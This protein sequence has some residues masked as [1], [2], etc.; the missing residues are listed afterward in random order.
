MRNLSQE[1]KANIWNSTNSIHINSLKRRKTAYTDLNRCRKASD[2]I[3]DPFLIKNLRKRIEGK[4]PQRDK[5]HLWKT[6]I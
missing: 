5:G 1:F 4:F 2:K 3:Q 6:Y